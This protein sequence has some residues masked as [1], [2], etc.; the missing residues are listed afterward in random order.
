M[1]RIILLACTLAASC[2]AQPFNGIMGMGITFQRLGIEMAFA[3]VKPEGSMFEFA[4]GYAW[5]ADEINNGKYESMT[6]VMGTVNVYDDREDG[7]F[8]DYS[9]F[10]F[11]ILFATPLE[12]DQIFLLHNIGYT[13]E[14]QTYFNK[15]YDSYEILGNNGRYFLESS[16]GSK[17]DRGF[18][19]GSTF[20]YR[21]NPDSPTKIYIYGGGMLSSISGMNGRLGLALGLGI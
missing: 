1:K 4:G 8:T 6:S 13:S 19:I 11:G 21:Y 9:D 20:Y 18:E 5:A 14:K 16:K 17:K 12:K 3:G 2:L 7:E 10:G 15:Y